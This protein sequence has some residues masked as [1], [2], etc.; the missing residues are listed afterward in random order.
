MCAWWEQS[1]FLNPFSLF[2]LESLSLLFL[3]ISTAVAVLALTSFGFANFLTGQTCEQYCA[4]STSSFQLLPKSPFSS[5]SELCHQQ[6]LH[7]NDIATAAPKPT[8]TS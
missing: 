8:R 4:G 2:Q 5:S 7:C 3:N 6:R 1:I